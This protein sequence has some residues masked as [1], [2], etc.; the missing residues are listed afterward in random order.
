MTNT[1]KPEWCIYYADGTTFD[2]NDGEP[3]EAPSE[4]FLCA[5]GYEQDGSRYIMHS[6]NYY[7]WDK[8][9][10]VW[11]GFDRQGL[12]T[13]LRHNGEIYAYKEG[14]TVPK[15]I[16]SKTVSAA[17]QHPDFPMKRE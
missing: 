1:Q 10:R 4:F 6:W 2:S 9:T 5:L 15:E 8:E 7:R 13:R 16:W 17:N 12:H 11:W 14:Y 3:H